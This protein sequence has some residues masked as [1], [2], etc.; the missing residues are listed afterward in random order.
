MKKRV[1]MLSLLL[2]FF[3]SVCL[4]QTKTPVPIA[5]LPF[6][7]P[8]NFKDDYISFS[9]TWLQEGSSTY[10]FQHPTSTQIYCSRLTTP[11]NC[12]VVTA[13]TTENLMVDLQL[14]FVDRWTSTEIVAVD[15]AP[16]CYKNVLMMRLTEKRVSLTLIPVSTDKAGCQKWTS[17]KTIALQ[18]KDGRKIWKEEI[19]KNCKKY[20]DNCK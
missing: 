12:S 11:Y 2:F 14:F 6:Y 8:N 18:L 5:P 19:R 9:G 1:I 13:T 10:D 4:A 15:D 3:G 16:L 20:F 7:F 17:Q